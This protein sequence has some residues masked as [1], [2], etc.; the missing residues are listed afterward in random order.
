VPDVDG[1]MLEPD[2]AERLFGGLPHELRP[3]FDCDDVWRRW[4]DNVQ[5]QKVDLRPSDDP[6]RYLCAFVY[7][8]SMSWFYRRGEDRPVM[9]CHVPNLLSEDEV[10]LGVEVVVALIY[11]LVAS[12]EKVGLRDRVVKEMKE[13]VAP[14]DL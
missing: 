1:H 9:F 3:S 11:A 12:R 2:E 4:R 13:D 10:K 8:L 7:Y 6:G 14:N 5:D